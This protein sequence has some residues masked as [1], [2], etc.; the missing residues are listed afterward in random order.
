MRR[1]I[2][3]LL[4][5][6]ALLS[7]GSLQS[8]GASNDNVIDIE[9]AITAASKYLPQFYKEEWI[10]Y[11]HFTYFDLDN[12]PSAYAIVF[13]KMDSEV[14][15]L[16][17]MKKAIEKN[18]LEI[19]IINAHIDTIQNNPKISGKEKNGAIMELYKKIISIKDSIQGI[20]R[21]ATVLTGAVDTS[22]V[23]LKCHKGMPE[24]FYK[25]LD[26]REILSKEFPGKQFN[27]SKVY[28]LGL[29]DIFYEFSVTDESPGSG[30]FHSI[31]GEGM[32]FHF[33]TGKLVSSR[34]IRTKF[35]EKK[36]LMKQE[37][38][39]IHIQKNK[40]RWEKFKQAKEVQPKNSNEAQES[41]SQEK[42]LRNEGEVRRF[43]NE[44]KEIENSQQLTRKGKTTDKVEKDEKQVK[45]EVK[46]NANLQT[47][48]KVEKSKE[49]KTRGQR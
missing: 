49:E 48:S 26:T 22:P 35:E 44:S 32:L 16:E 39:S 10:Y 2:F 42:L 17:E 40:E 1:W 20:D 31:G 13:K 23:V 12:R 3:I 25:E 46:K 9:V 7:V 21:F 4:F 24:A 11:T 37:S 45:V 30:S 6:L 36:L 38:D 15:S 5:T 8:Q 34:E 47:P 18:Y 43:S 28:Y 14:E 33:R 27:I 41:T 19:K 29:F